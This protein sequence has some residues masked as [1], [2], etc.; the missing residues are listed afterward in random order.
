[1]TTQQSI[2]S[3]NHP[4]KRVGVLITNLGT[5]D[6]PTKTALRRYLKEFLWDPR[7]VQIPRFIWWIILNLFILPFRPKKSAKL[8]ESIWTE[9]GS[10]LLVHTKNLAAKLS[11]KINENWGDEIV[12]DFAMRYGSNAIDEK[13]QQMVANGVNRFLVIPL[14]PQYSE[15][16][17]ASTLDAIEQ[18]FKK[19]KQQPE[20]RFIDNYHDFPEYIN[21]CAN[22]IKQRCKMPDCNG[23]LLFSFH[24]LPQS[25]VDNGDPYYEQC[26]KTSR[27]IAT[28][29]N[30]KQ[31]E[32]FTTFQSRFG[33]AEWLKPYTEDT[34]KSLPKQGV[35]SIHVFC[36]GFSADCLETLE[37]IDHENRQH[38]LQSGGE[39]FQYIPALNADPMHVDMLIKLIENNLK[40][41]H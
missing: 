13:I 41:W 24:G 16:T 1:M 23:N 39:N 25:F 10:P 28:E 11:E 21:A 35:K 27:L 14:Y 17:T 18:S 15:T 5:P 40:E 4:E 26:L 8:Y 19:L 37:E 22:Q 20:L 30:L 3:N 33:K 2:N 6:A 34:L 31:D 7:V 12:L 36:P 29:L 38:F 9:E 32:F